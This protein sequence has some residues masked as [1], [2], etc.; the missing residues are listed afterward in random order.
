M[1]ILAIE[2]SCD[3][4][5]CAIVE[6]GT[7]VLANKIASQIDI[8]QKT[9]GV[10]PEVA[11]REHILQMTAVLDQCLI[12]ANCD[13]KDIEAIAVT[14]GPGLVSSL[15]IGTQAAS[16]ISY[17]KNIPLV[18]VHHI[19]GHIYSAWIGSG[20]NQ[21]QFPILVLTVSGG[22]NELI[23]FKDHDNFE[24]IGQT[25]DDAAG[26]AFDKVA[27]MLEMGYPGGPA[28]AKAALDGDSSTYP[29][30]RVMLEKGS[31]DFSFSGLKSAVRREIQTFAKENKITDIKKLPKQFKSDLA[32]SF[33]DAVT[34]V[35]RNKLF[36]A[37]ELY[38]EVKELHLVGG[39]S[40]NLRLRELIKTHL[41]KEQLN[42]IFRYPEK[43]EY[44]TDN[45]AMIGCAAYF[46]YR[47]NSQQFSDRRNI[48]PNTNF[49]L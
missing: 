46:L 11:A 24:I 42:L 7:T 31:F 18:P 28:I 45:A 10:V 4:T 49:M 21:P 8:H 6:N 35:L 47:Q 22:H 36:N 32:A 3:E 37:V 43:I 23:Y 41:E 30:P 2:T 12:D 20:E 39:V 38:P 29:L 33:Q 27:R 9:G 13:W 26:E 16:T 44:C 19:M 48:V 40:A 17:A 1:K 34:E 5:A 15:M 25:L 14:K